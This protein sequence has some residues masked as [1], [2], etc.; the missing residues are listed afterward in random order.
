MTDSQ[1]D[2]QPSQGLSGRRVT[3]VVLLLLVVLGGTLA[4]ALWSYSQLENIRA[5][6]RD[7][8]SELREPLAARYREIEKRVAVGVDGGNIPIA[9]AEKFRLAIDQFRT[10]AQPADQYAVAEQ[11]EGLVGELS[12]PTVV[13]SAANVPGAIVPAVSPEVSA[14]LAK[15]NSQLDRETEQLASPGC[16]LLDVFLAFREPGQFELAQ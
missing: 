8:W 10:T 9:W 2:S 1:Q 16:Q 13:D 15:F 14:A 5:D 11:V 7:A 6:Q 12:E 4:Y 3:Q